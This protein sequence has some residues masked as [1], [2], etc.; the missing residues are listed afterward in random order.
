[1]IQKFF[2]NLQRQNKIIHFSKV[3]A[4]LKIPLKVMAKSRKISVEVVKVGNQSYFNIFE[5]KGETN[6]GEVVLIDR[7]LKEEDAIK[8]QELYYETKLYKVIY[9]RN[10]MVWFK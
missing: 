3:G 7:Y 1:M 9:V 10:Q 4:T 2:L 6:D 5:V 8:C